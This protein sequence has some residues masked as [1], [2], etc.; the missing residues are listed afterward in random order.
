[1]QALQSDGNNSILNIKWTERQIHISLI[2]ESADNLRVFFDNKE[3]ELLAEDIRRQGLIYPLIV[4]KISKNVYEIIDGHRRYR[5]LKKANIKVVTCRVCDYPLSREQIQAL[6]VATDRFPKL[7]SK[8]DLAKRCAVLNREIG[9][10][11]VA[12]AKMIMSPQQ[13]R[14]YALVG[15]LAGKLMQKLIEGNVPYTFTHVATIFFATNILCKRV[16][17]TKDEVVDAL[18]EKW[19]TKKIKSVDEFRECTKKVPMLKDEDIKHWLTS[20]LGIEVLKAMVEV[21]P[22]RHEKMVESINKSLGQISRKIREYTFT[23]EEARQVQD[24]LTLLQKEIK[25]VVE[26]ARRKEKK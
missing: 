5:A 3:L 16:S 11:A 10:L 1:M 15:E 24:Q 6:M 13:F 2:T 18:A 19:I 9:S 20:D 17:M 25:R 12:S 21:V 22:G 14:L 8:Y 4:H 23:F 7:W 26:V